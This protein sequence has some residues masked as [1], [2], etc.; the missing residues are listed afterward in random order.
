MTWAFL[1]QT[2]M[3]R[4]TSHNAF[5]SV[6]SF[7]QMSL[8]L[9]NT[10]LPAAQVSSSYYFKGLPES[11]Q[12]VSQISSSIHFQVNTLLQESFCLDC[13]L[14]QQN[15]CFRGGV[16]PLK[17][18]ASLLHSLLGNQLLWVSATP[19]FIGLL[20]TLCGSDL[21]G[22]ICSCKPMPTLIFSSFHYHRLWKCLR[23]Q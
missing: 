7:T 17:P 9:Q 21:E 23:T 8:Q 11:L 15:V 12:L 10:A 22:M 16:M 20:Q 19:V 6:F 4:V 1:V 5:V 14:L 3:P 2:Q 13:I 18:S